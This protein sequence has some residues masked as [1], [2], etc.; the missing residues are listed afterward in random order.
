MYSKIKYTDD[1]SEETGVEDKKRYS[2]IQH[3]PYS[4]D[5]APF[6]IAFFSTTEIG[7]AWKL[8]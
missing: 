5:L 7:S 1:T 6:G 2:R 4:R 8:V 3:A